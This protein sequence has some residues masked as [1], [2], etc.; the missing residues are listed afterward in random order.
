MLGK[1]IEG[2][3]GQKESKKHFIIGVQEIFEGLPL[4]A[5]KLLYSYMRNYL[6]HSGFLCTNVILY[7]DIDGS[8]DLMKR[9]IV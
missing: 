4:N 9:R 8:W 7:D 2:F 5:A 6:Y 3:E 1:H